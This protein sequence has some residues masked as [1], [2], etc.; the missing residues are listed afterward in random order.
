MTMV[1]VANGYLNKLINRSLIQVIK[2]DLD[3]SIIYCNIHDIWQEIILTKTR[4]QNLVMLSTSGDYTRLKENIRRIAIH[5]FIEN[6]RSLL[7]FGYR[8]PLNESSLSKLL[9]ARPKL[10]NVLD[11]GRAELKSIPKEVFKLF[12]LKYLNLQDTGV[13]IISQSIGNLQN[14]EYLNLVNTLVMALPIGI[15]KLRKLRELLVFPECDYSK[16]FAVHGFKTP[17]E[18]GRLLSLE[19]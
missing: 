1:E 3:G 19:V 5:G 16:N 18:I 17:R 14:L 6:L 11:L 7:I 8:N 2:L 13:E 10:L 4:E 15:L 12:H 9:S